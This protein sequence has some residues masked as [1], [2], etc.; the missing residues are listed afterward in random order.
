MAFLRIWYVACFFFFSRLCL[1]L[2]VKQRVLIHYCC[3]YCSFLSNIHSYISSIIVLLDL[4]ATTVH[5][6]ALSRITLWHCVFNQSLKIAIAWSSFW[7]HLLWTGSCKFPRV[8]FQETKKLL[9]ALNTN[10]VN[11]TTVWNLYSAP[12]K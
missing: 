12:F 9:Q 8:H 5:F 11:S 1:S 4:L 6:E 10:S 2:A 7:K 3:C